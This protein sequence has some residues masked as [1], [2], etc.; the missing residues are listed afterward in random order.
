MTL[1]GKKSVSRRT[2]KGVK[3]NRQPH[4]EL[5]VARKTRVFDYLL[6]MLSI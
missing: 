4:S 5:P 3:T 2:E 1:S 6:W